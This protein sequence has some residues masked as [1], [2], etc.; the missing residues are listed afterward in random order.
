MPCIGRCLKSLYK[1]VAKMTRRVNSGPPVLA[2]GLS[3]FFPQKTRRV[4]KNTP[5][6]SKKICLKIQVPFAFFNGF[7][8]VLYHFMDRRILREGFLGGAF[9]KRIAFGF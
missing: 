2:E 3:A 6:V 4:L 7:E 1:A 5:G 9:N 8:V